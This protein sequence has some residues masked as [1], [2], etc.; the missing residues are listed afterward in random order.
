MAIKPTYRD[1]INRRAVYTFRD[2]ELFGKE[3][4]VA[5]L[6][7]REYKPSPPKELSFLPE[8]AFDSKKSA[9]PNEAGRGRQNSHNVS[10]MNETSSS[11]ST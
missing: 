1:K 4:E 5:L 7:E 8:L 9:I 10:A 3:F 11:K 6:A 2:L